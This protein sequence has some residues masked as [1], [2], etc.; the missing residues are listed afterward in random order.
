M[1]FARIQH[2]KGFSKSRLVPSCLGLTVEITTIIRNSFPLPTQY[3]K[4]CFWLPSIVGLS[5]ADYWGRFVD[6]VRTALGEDR[7]STYGDDIEV[8]TPEHKMQT[9]ALAMAVITDQRFVNGFP[10]SNY[11]DHPWAKLKIDDRLRLAMKHQRIALY[12]YEHQR[13][14]FDSF[15]KE[16]KARLALQHPALM[17]MLIREYNCL[18]DNLKR[19]LFFSIDEA[20]CDNLRYYPAATQSIQAHVDVAYA[21]YAKP[22]LFNLIPD[23]AKVSAALKDLPLA[24]KMVEE[25]RLATLDDKALN[26]FLGLCVVDRMNPLTREQRD[27]IIQAFVKKDELLARLYPVTRL[28]LFSRLHANRRLEVNP[29]LGR[30][31]SN[32]PYMLPSDHTQICGWLCSIVGL[33]DFDSW[34]R[35]ND[36]IRM[37]LGLERMWTN[38]NAE[39]D[40]DLLNILYK[41]KH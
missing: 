5:D 16:Q 26:Q 18:D 4:L 32:N 37:A 7:I 40:I 1:V 23:Y 34:G 12:T 14:L 36:V 10:N 41:Q 13:S 29:L 25:G 22:D 19:A 33:G 31:I 3:D 35:F 30:Q 17:L 20:T 15:T 27:K 28:F 9:E 21:L 38:S 2:M 39:Y 6:V 8:N 24:L 11:P